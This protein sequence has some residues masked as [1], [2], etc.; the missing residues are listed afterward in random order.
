MV[1]VIRDYQAIEHRSLARSSLGPLAMQQRLWDVSEILKHCR[2]Q[3]THRS[4]HRMQSKTIEKWIEAAMGAM[5]REA[6]EEQELSEASVGGE[7]SDEGIEGGSGVES[8]W[9]QDVDRDVVLEEPL[10]LKHNHLNNA[11]LNIY[12]SK[13]VDEKTVDGGELLSDVRPTKNSRGAGTAFEGDAGGNADIS[14]SGNVSNTNV[15]IINVN[16]NKINGNASNNISNKR[17]RK[18]A[19][20][21]GPELS[22]DAKRA[23]LMTDKYPPPTSKLSDLGGIDK[24]VE[25][26]LQLVGVPLKQPEVYIHLGIQPPRGI[27]LHGPPG[28]GKT[29]LAHA[30]AGEL[31]VPFINI[32]APAIVSGM[33]GESEK[34]IRE[35]FEE[36]R[37]CAPCVLFMDEIDAI[38]PKRETA[39][40][41]MERR[42]VAQLLTCI[43]DMSLEKTNNKAVMLIGATNRPDSIDP[44][45]RRAGR[46]DREIAMKVP[47]E[48][49]RLRIL[50]KLCERLRLVGDFDFHGLA[51]MTP[52][53]VGA[54]LKAL[55]AEAGLIAVTRIFDTLWRNN[56]SGITDTAVAN[57]EANAALAVT[58][59]NGEAS[60]TEMDVDIP[61]EPNRPPQFAKTLP[62]TVCSISHFLSTHTSPLTPE[63]LEPLHITSPDFLQAL[64]KVQPSAKREGF[65]TV[66][67]VTWDDIGALMPIRDALDWAIV[68]PMRFPDWFGRM[69]ELK[70]MG[71]LLY[72]PPGCGKTLL[73][74]AVASESCCNFISVKG[75]ELLN[76]YVGESERGI[77]QVFARAALSKPCVIFFD[78][79][80]ALCPARSNDAENQ[81]SSRLVNT[82][83]TE[84]DGMEDRSGVYIIAATNRPDMIDPAVIRPG[85]IDKALYVDLPSAP[86]RLEILKTITARKGT[87]LHA[88]LRADL[89]VVSSD[90]R[91]E[92]FSGADLA[93]LVREAAVAALRETLYGPGRDRESTVKDV[94]VWVT[95]RHFDQAFGRIT[96]SVSKGARKKYELLKMKFGSGVEGAKG[97]KEPKSTMRGKAADADDHGAFEMDLEEKEN[98]EDYIPTSQEL[99]SGNR[100]K[101]ATA[102][103]LQQ[104]EV[105]RRRLINEDEDDDE[106]P[107]VQMDAVGTDGSHDQDGETQSGEDEDGD[108][109]PR[110]E[111]SD[112]AEGEDEQKLED[113]EEEEEVPL[114][115]K[116]KVSKKGQKLSNSQVDEDAMDE[117]VEEESH[118]RKRGSK[119]KEGK[120]NGAEIRAKDDNAGTVEHVELVNFMCHKYLQISLCKNINFIVG[121]N[122]SGKSA[123]LTALT[124]CLGGK[125]TFTN[126]GTSVKSLLKEGE[127][128]GAVTIKVANRG[129]EAFHPEKYGET[130]I[131]ERKLVK[132]GSGGY[133]IKDANGT[134]VSTKKEDLT[135][136]CDH[137]S[138]AV[139][140]PMAVLT[141]DTSRMFLAGSSPKDK[142]TFFSQGT[143]L[144]QLSNDHSKVQD[145]ITRANGTIAIKENALPELKRDYDDWKHKWAEI[146]K[147]ENLEREIEDSKN[148]LAWA[149]VRDQKELRDRI[150]EE[151]AVSYAKMSKADPKIAEL[152]SKIEEL[153]HAILELQELVEG[154][155]GKGEQI[156]ARK[157]ELHRELIAK[158]RLL[159]AHESEEDRL[160]SE[161]N[162]DQRLSNDLAVKIR[163]E[164]KKLQDS[165]RAVREEKEKAVEEISARL[166]EIEASLSELKVAER[167]EEEKVETLSR[168]MR[169]R[170][171]AAEQALE[172]ARHDMQT[173]E[174]ALK[175]VTSN[176]GSRLG[177][178]PRGTEQALRHIKEETNRGGWRGM[179]PIGPI[180]MYCKLKEPKYGFVIE[181][182]LNSTLNAFIVDRKEDADTLKR[183]FRSI[184]NEVVKRQ[185]VLNGHIENTVLVDTRQQGDA[186]SLEGNLHRRKIGAIY[187]KDNVRLG[188]R[189]GGLMTTGVNPA[190][191]GQPRIEQDISHV[192][193][194]KQEYLDDKKRELQHAQQNMKN[195]MPDW[196]EVNELKKFLKNM[197]TKARQLELEKAR[198]TERK[199][200]LVDEIQDAAPGNITHLETFKEES[201]RKIAANQGQ[202]ET[203]RG[204]KSEVLAET[205]ALEDQLKSAS[206]EIDHLNKEMRNVANSH[207]KK[208]EEAAELQKN[209]AHYTRRRAEYESEYNLKAAQLENAENEL[210]AAEEKALQMTKERIDVGEVSSRDILKRI[211]DDEARLKENRKQTGSK[212]EVHAKLLQTKTQYDTAV[213]E[214]RSTRKAIESIARAL[215]NRVTQWYNLRR[216]ISIEAKSQFSKL[217]MKR[218]FK[219]W[220]DIDHDKQTLE[221]RVDVHNG[222]EGG[223]GNEKDPRT[224]S[225]GEKSFSTIC[226]LLSLWHYIGNPFRALDEFDVFMDPER[227]QQTLNFP[228]AGPSANLSDGEEE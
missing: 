106:T 47:D 129:S 53:Y 100:R 219:A 7:G 139:N 23:R 38:T 108:G 59:A 132:D 55:V 163:D 95:G 8:P 45:L 223:D 79:L 14:N 118:R 96:P 22:P 146:V 62:T 1:D 19:T 141:Q 115:K 94:E 52:G 165:A 199:H 114:R 167:A 88:D 87:P 73:A 157:N 58:A 71:V 82:L 160:N 121:H 33:S 126:R 24:C 127:K 145:H 98:E 77:R 152:E 140:N 78:E 117:D 72:G 39:Q 181:S 143:L 174:K 224:L 166:K 80:D 107:F 18:L 212:E 68:K 31:Q 57:G 172:A 164:T 202:L 64:K 35:I 5:R 34:K 227:N 142:Y 194:E 149:I 137:L 159:A 90:A 171:Y 69:G 131:I 196:T 84:L 44:A 51:K 170:K 182:Y 63:E 148:R 65:A 135:A 29:A 180:G 221:L 187:T 188:G 42:I 112:G 54:D 13:A 15:S 123:I 102:A 208:K 147:S 191:R 222:K 48:E 67:D 198:M 154:G 193:R 177:G 97:L 200:V 12:A 184:T 28:C 138:I 133:K 175:D 61:A 185:L 111:G 91:C 56:P 173:A 195:S 151:T 50:L 37:E 99:A 178:F 209:K 60:A 210:K 218:G 74:K 226:L 10:M 25:D 30:I 116:P 128:V 92:G 220:L 155:R 49:G 89:A 136:I 205:R 120:F 41:E 11:L 85:R 192:I 101:F 70:S 204:Q 168:E 189:N 216:L 93:A 144:A 225:G 21:D 110:K 3:Q 32:S 162:K 150:E 130:I 158:R 211:K 9:C 46:F 179:V 176:K 122:G 75:P 16:N 81:S 26:M 109:L 186:L 197:H 105:K 40:R 43:D 228:G 214:L 183:I 125:A 119:A 206:A 190:Y 203:A 169:E 4:F 66:P 83:L 153:Q 20:G 215:E 86:E 2:K 213:A 201:D 161:I 104:S 124:I 217:M 134:T 156:G 207:R 17:S 76:K 6:P 113:D 27:L 103:S 36:A